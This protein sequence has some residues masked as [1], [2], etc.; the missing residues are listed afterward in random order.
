MTSTQNCNE[1]LSN[2]VWLIQ[3]ASAAIF[4]RADPEN[5]ERGGRVPHPP[6]HFSG[7]AAYSIVGGFVMQS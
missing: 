7:D 6:L 5:S 1:T 2:T 3:Y 4:A